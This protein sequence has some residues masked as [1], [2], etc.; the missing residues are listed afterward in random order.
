MALAMCVNLEKDM[1][2]TFQKALEGRSLEVFAIDDPSKNWDKFKEMLILALEGATLEN[3]KGSI[4]TKCVPLIT[5][6]QFIIDALKS[7]DPR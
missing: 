6:N 2:H 5:A 4:S 7:E 1:S 3:E